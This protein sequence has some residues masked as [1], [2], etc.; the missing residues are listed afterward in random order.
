MGLD[1]SHGCWHGPYSAFSRWRVALQAAAGW[2]LDEVADPPFTFIESRVINW[3]ALNDGNFEGRWESIPEDPLIVLIAH[4]DCSGL[5][6]VPA[7]IPL[8]E[9][10]EGLAA[11]MGPTD[12]QKTDEWL[13]AF[14]HRER[15]ARANYDGERAATLRFAAGL[16]I[17][18]A[19]NE[20]V[21]FH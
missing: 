21:E 9:R 15:P 19:A 1:T 7:L 3:A 8:A 20:P 14:D 6:P 16:R 11:K 10:L 18:A 2:P 5:I 17:A 4:S 12:G 13:A